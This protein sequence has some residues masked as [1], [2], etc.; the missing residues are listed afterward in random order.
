MA[1]VVPSFSVPGVVIEVRDLVTKE[2]KVWSHSVKVMAM[3]GT[4]ELQTQD[5]A[6][7]KR[8]KQN[9]EGEAKGRF[10]NYKGWRFIVT[11]WVPRA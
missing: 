1:V 4:F 5:E 3:G 7:A 11:D 9:Q 6:L 10:E 2:G 8:F